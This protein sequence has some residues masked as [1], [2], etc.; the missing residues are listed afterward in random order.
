MVRSEREALASRTIMM[1]RD[2]SLRDAPHHG[3]SGW[4]ETRGW[5]RAPHHEGVVDPRH[6]RAGGKA[7]VFSSP[8]SFRSEFF[9]PQSSQGGSMIDRRRL[10]AFGAGAAF[11]SAIAKISLD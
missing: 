2:A 10:L 3:S 1:V 6:L 8:G 7:L 11:A 5:R 9:Q 4:F